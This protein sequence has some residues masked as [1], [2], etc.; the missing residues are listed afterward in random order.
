MSE[1]QYLNKLK[2]F[3][4][5]T[6]EFVKY[7]KES[8]QDVHSLRVKSRE[9]FSLLSPEEPIR[10]KIKK[11]IKTS[12][13]IRDIDVFVENYIE[14]LPKKLRVKLDMKSIIEVVN[15]SRGE[16]IE[17]LHKYLG[18]LEINNTLKFIEA[19]QEIDAIRSVILDFDQSELHKYRIFIKKMLFR[20]KNAFKKDEKK[21]KLLTKIKDILGDINDNSN[22]VK[23]LSGYNVE[24]ELF[25]DIEEFTQKRNL[26]LFKEFKKQNDKYMKALL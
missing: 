21:V 4:Q 7:K 18:S 22:G 20:E 13:E 23:R 5:Y 3:K 25:K 24:E 8:V 11:V 15:K 2:E 19:N 10:K 1:K 14:S 26:K 17:K 16:E 12:N 6:S 9:L